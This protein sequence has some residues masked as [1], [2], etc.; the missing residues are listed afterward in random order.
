MYKLGKMYR[1]GKGGPVDYAKARELY[2]KA[3][4]GGNTDAIREMAS[5]NI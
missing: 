4:E 1:D 3:A 5:L 2:E